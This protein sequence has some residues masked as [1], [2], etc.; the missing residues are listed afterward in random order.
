MNPKLSTV[1]LL[2][3][4]MA[5]K[6]VSD[7]LPA[8]NNLTAFLDDYLKSHGVW[9]RVERVGKRNALYAA[10]RRTRSPRILAVTHLDVVPAEPNLFTMRR[11]GDWLFGRGVG[12][13]LGNAAVLAQTLIRL[14]GQANTGGI[15]STD[16]EIGGNTTAAFVQRGYTG[17]AILVLDSSGLKPHLMVAQKG[18]LALRL[19]AKGK[20]CHS[21]TPWAGSNAIDKLIEGYIKARAL[22]PPVRPND[23][24]HTTI[25][26]NV[27]RGGAVHNRVPDEAELILD[28]RWTEAVNPSELVRRIKK[29]SGLKV[30][31]I[32]KCPALTTNPEQPIVRKFSHA[33]HKAFGRAPIIGRLNGATDARHFATMKTPTIITSIPYEGP[34]ASNERASARGIERFETF[35]RDFLSSPD[36]L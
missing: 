8:V 5:F 10:T 25:S 36:C 26:A 4:M 17:G 11:N 29:A 21:S 7:D 31:I 35:L 33:M 2:K 20:A 32:A 27:I 23:T 24:W 18:I 13:C 22:I 19:S 34:H 1:N 30:E 14:N 16:E 12:D 3:K 15:F 9:T 6:P 28:I